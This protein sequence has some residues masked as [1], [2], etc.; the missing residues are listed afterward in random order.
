MVFQPQRE[1]EILHSALT[2]FRE[3]KLSE[4]IIWSITALHKGGCD[5]QGWCGSVTAAIIKSMY[6]TGRCVVWKLGA[7]YNISF[8]TSLHSSNACQLRR[9]ATILDFSIFMSVTNVATF[10]TP[11]LGSLRPDLIEQV[12]W[13]TAMLGVRVMWKALIVLAAFLLA[14]LLVNDLEWTPETPYCAGLATTGLD[15]PTRDPK[16]KSN[17]I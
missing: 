1:A 6:I 14:R 9:C 16:Q 11:E 8:R 7:M 3:A 15:R 12:D 13:I 10:K 4:C 17:A 2:F 5:G